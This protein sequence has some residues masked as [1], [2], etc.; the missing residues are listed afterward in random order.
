VINVLATIVALV[1]A[2]NVPST[3]LWAAQ[4]AARPN[5]SGD[6]KMNAAKSNFGV[7]PA[8]DSITRKITHVDSSLTII[9]EQRSSMGDQSMTRKYVTDG[10][11]TTFEINGAVVTS[12]ATWDENTLVVVSRLESFGLSF[13]DK[14]TLSADGTTLTSQVH[15]TSPM[16]D[17]DLTVVYDK[18]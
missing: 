5:F 12:A 16:G 6:W 2:L 7:M 18:Q 17:V 15:V 9:E 13:N 10:T 3:A 1:L 14:M 4:A 8:P 11:E